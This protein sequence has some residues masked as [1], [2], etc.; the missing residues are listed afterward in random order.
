MNHFGMV[1][2]GFVDRI[3]QHLDKLGRGDH[4]V[5]T[6]VGVRFACRLPDGLNHIGWNPRH[7]AQI[8]N[9]V[10]AV[11]GAVNQTVIRVYQAVV[12]FH[13]P[14]CVIHVAD[15]GFGLV[16]PDNLN[17]HEYPPSR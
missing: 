6:L 10:H 2:D 13:S 5:Y 7:L 3:N 15:D 12:V 8:V 4:D 16:V 11:I 14:L 17:A 9:D 1:A